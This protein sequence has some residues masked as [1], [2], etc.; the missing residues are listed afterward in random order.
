MSKIRDASIKFAY[1]V[2]HL[3]SQ[4]EVSRIRIAGGETLV[5]TDVACRTGDYFTLE[6]GWDGDGCPDGELYGDLTVDLDDEAYEFGNFAHPRN[7]ASTAAVR[8]LMKNKK[9]IRDAIKA[10]EEENKKLIES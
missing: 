4:A 5:L 3:M 1:E 9:A 8:M 7:P 2:I 6:W 10:I